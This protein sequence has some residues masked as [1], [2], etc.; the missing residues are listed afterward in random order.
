VHREENKFSTICVEHKPEQRSHCVL[1]SVRGIGSLEA[2]DFATAEGRRLQSY[3][4]N[5]LDFNVI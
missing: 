3:V 4:L 1:L 2:Q 5:V